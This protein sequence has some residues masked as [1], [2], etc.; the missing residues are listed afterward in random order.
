MQDKK[1]SSFELD[2]LKENDSETF[3]NMAKSNLETVFYLKTKCI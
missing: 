1:E 3:F 2:S